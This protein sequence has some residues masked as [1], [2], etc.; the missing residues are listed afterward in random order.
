MEIERISSDELLVR[1]ASLPDVTAS[2]TWVEQ[3]RRELGGQEKMA[4]IDLTALP[5]V[6]SLVVGVVL[7]VFKALQK[8]GGTI[9]VTVPREEMRHVFEL[10]RLTS[11]FEVE[12]ADGVGETTS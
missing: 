12:V 5:V 7:G 8:Q 4:R 2:G 9:R 3:F 6:S 11:M 10:F 1:I